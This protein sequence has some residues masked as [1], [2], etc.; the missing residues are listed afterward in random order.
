[1]YSSVF[2]GQFCIENSEIW[3]HK[4]QWRKAKLILPYNATYAS[5][6]IFLLFLKEHM[7]KVPYFLFL[8][9]LVFKNDVFIRIFKIFLAFLQWFV[10][11]FYIVINKN[12]GPKYQRILK[13]TQERGK[14]YIN[15]HFLNQ[16]QIFPWRNF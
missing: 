4:I 11:I 10:S 1:M 8:L 16:Q 7:L 6:P 2:L 13:F 3:I 14:C 12:I 5:I 9:V 15:F